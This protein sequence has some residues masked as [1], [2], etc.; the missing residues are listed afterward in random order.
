MATYYVA[1]TGS[2]GGTG[3]IGDPWKT[4]Q[5]GV[6]Q[7]SGGDT[8]LIRAGTYNEAVSV[9]AAASGTSGA[10][11]TI[12]AYTGE[13]VVIDGE[14]A[15]PTGAIAP[16]LRKAIEAGTVVPI[17]GSPNY[18]FV[19][20]GATVYPATVSPLV[21]IGGNWVDF[22]DI[23][24]TRSLGR[25]L[26]IFSATGHHDNVTVSNCE[27]SYSRWH[28]VTAYGDS[29]TLDGCDIHH[30]NMFAPFSRSAS[31]SAGGMNW[32]S[33]IGQAESTNLTVKNCKIHEHWGEGIILVEGTIVEDC[34][35][36]LCYS[37]HCY[38]EAADGAVARRNL[39]WHNGDGFLR[40][41]DVINGINLT[42]EPGTTAGTGG[43]TGGRVYNNIVVGCG[44]SVVMFKGDGYYS[45]NRVYNNTFVNPVGKDPRLVVVGA[46]DTDDVYFYNNIF[47]TSG[48]ATASNQSVGGSASFYNNCWYGLT[49]SAALTGSGDI[50]A[51]PQ[52]RD[53]DADI[54]N[55]PIA[56][57]YQLLEDSPCI[58][59]ATATPAVPTDDYF[60]NSRS[61]PDIGAHEYGGTI[62]NY[63]YPDF[64]GSGRTGTAPLTVTLTDASTSNETITARYWYYRLTGATTWLL[65]DDGN[66]TSITLQINTSGDYDVRL[67][68]V[69]AS[70]ETS[71]VKTAF[72]NAASSGED[73]NA[74]GTP[75]TGGSG[76][77]GV[78]T[79]AANTST[80]TQTITLNNASIT[81]TFALVTCMAA[82][83]AGTA[84][85]N[86]LLSVGMTDGTRT[87]AVG[88]GAE[89]AVATSNAGRALRNDNIIVISNY[90]TTRTAYA[91]FVNFDVGSVTIN[92]SVA[93]PAGYIINVWAIA[94][95]DAYVADETIAASV[96]NTTPNF[97][98]DVIFWIAGRGAFPASGN[99]TNLA[100]GV[101]TADTTA[102]IATSWNDA[103]AAGEVAAYAFDG[104]VG[105]IND[106]GGVMWKFTP[107]ITAT[108]WS[109]ASLDS[110]TASGAV[111]Y[112]CLRLA[113]N[114]VWCDMVDTETST[115]T[116]ANTTPA[117]LGGAAVGVFSLL[118]ASGSASTTATGGSMA[119][120]LWADTAQYA[121]GI[122]T[123]YN[124]DPTVSKSHASVNRFVSVVDDDGTTT[125]LQAYISANAN[126]Y[127]LGWETV[128]GSAC[129][130]VMLLIEGEA[131]TG[132]NYDWFLP[133][134]TAGLL[135]GFP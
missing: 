124:A 41:G 75:V 120:G 102:T 80:G 43:G 101:T 132:G 87:R 97:Q 60:S 10:H 70:Q 100:V 104:S 3:A 7:L 13:T 65:V 29:D 42:N 73:P 95:D 114:S 66:N 84:G 62:T 57:N 64:T 133:G 105:Q 92:W 14:Y 16:P 12:A 23:K 108:G 56:A 27:I 6:D 119:L 39:I 5:Y 94:A 15:I 20:N 127:N 134:T 77:V 88:V 24:I 38:L 135:A 125:A 34:E 49:P 79:A 103:A 44:I 91:T 9:P 96:T 118:T 11:T 2:N 21:D 122:T 22:E 123:E 40:G 72:I 131:A 53:P 112:G 90:S 78:G 47:Y 32:G 86:A 107:S 81:P 128:Q 115:G 1:T 59:A 26:R 4:I 116:A 61:T 68:A 117:F 46:C 28:T 111:A 106:T 113:S 51:N 63:L 18:R 71:V 93:P 121:S 54:S 30:S 98:S 126:G 36:Y 129:K 52:M 8:L 85:D 31:T 50:Y 110:G 33:G 74:P 67:R 55:G 35:I 48:G 76:I 37:A 130:A 83:T 89:D 82:T 25:G 99:D 45:N 69:T 17:S 58:G 109:Y 19:Q